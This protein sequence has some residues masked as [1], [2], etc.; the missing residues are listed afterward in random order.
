VVRVRSLAKKAVIPERKGRKKG[1]EPG[2]AY[3]AIALLEELHPI[4][5]ALSP[6]SLA[7][8]SRT[9][10]RSDTVFLMVPPPWLPRPTDWP[11]LAQC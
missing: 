7:E 9:K 10:P 2:V 1:R 6:S 5:G 3:A 4:V 8:D 11:A